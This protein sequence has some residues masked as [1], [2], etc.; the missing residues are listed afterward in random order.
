MQIDMHYY[1]TYALARAAGLHGDAARTVATCAQF[2]D[3]SVHLTHKEMRDH[4]QVDPVL[5]AHDFTDP[6]IG[7][8]DKQRPVWIPFH[9]LP[10]GA[11]GGREDAPFLERIVCRQDSPI[12]REMLDHYLALPRSSYSLALMGVAA[13]VYADTFSHYGFSGIG[14]RLNFVRGDSIVCHVEDQGIKGYIEDKATGFF[15]SL[16]EK[17]KRFEVGA[18]QAAELL[19]RGLGHGGVATYPDRPYLRWEFT[20]EDSGLTVSRDNR[21]TFLAACRNLHE[22]FA[23]FVARH[24]RYADGTGRPFAAIEDAVKAILAV[25]ADKD[26]R[27]DAWQDAARTGRLWDGE[28]REIPDY[29]G[30]AWSDFVERLPRRAS[31]DGVPDHPVY[32]FFQAA[33]YHRTYVLRD[34]LPA[35]GIVVV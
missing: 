12:A 28:N 5:T 6:D 26:G 3:D 34:L 18:A 1:G 19:S 15:D 22:R 32:R 35:H 7:Q 27:I 33:A 21:A 17:L 20:Y 23:H 9:F 8:D 4:A 13:H 25:E 29:D 2:V 30:E 31:G 16:K 14:S 24:D 11:P 10:G